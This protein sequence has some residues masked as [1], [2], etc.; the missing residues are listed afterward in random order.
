MTHPHQEGSRENG[1]ATGDISGTIKCQ[2]RSRSRRCAVSST[3]VRCSGAPPYQSRG[4]PSVLHA[5]ISF[6]HLANPTEEKP[7]EKKLHAFSHQPH[8]K[9]C[10]SSREPSMYV[11]SRRKVRLLIPTLLL[12]ASCHP[13]CPAGVLRASW[14][15]A[16]RQRACCRWTFCPFRG[17]SRTRTPWRRPRRPEGCPA[18]TGETIGRRILLSAE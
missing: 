3:T 5:D 1:I 17:P 8:P 6:R 15:G 13:P 14:E 16:R 12:A 11:L 7:N 9:T 18:W 2:R 10:A 4:W